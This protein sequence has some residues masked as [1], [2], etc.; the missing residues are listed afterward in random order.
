M[1]GQ[2]RSKCPTFNR[3]LKRTEDYFGMDI[4]ATRFNYYRDA[5]DWKPFHHDAAAIKPRMAKNQNFTVGISFGKER[6]CVFQHSK[7]GTKI[8]CPQPNGALYAFC[9]DVNIEWKHGVWAVLKEEL[10]KS[11]QEPRQGGEFRS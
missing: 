10:V 5:S 2:W 11:L 8:S 7:K 6:E 9:R 1:R 4:K 3:V